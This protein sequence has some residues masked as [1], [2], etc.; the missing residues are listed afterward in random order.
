[1]ERKGAHGGVRRVEG[2]IYL[3]AACADKIIRQKM[4]G[5]DDGKPSEGNVQEKGNGGRRTARSGTDESGG[6]RGRT[7]TGEIGRTRL[8]GG[9]GRIVLQTWWMQRKSER[10]REGDGERYRGRT[11]RRMKG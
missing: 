3:P 11:I 10:K 8:K 1:M 9:W 7:N 6:A 5:V 4:P 2:E